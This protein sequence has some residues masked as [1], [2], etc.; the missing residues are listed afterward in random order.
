[1]CGYHHVRPDG[2]TSCRNAVFGASR[3]RSMPIRGCPPPTVLVP[4]APRDHVNWRTGSNLPGAAGVEFSLASESPP[5]VTKSRTPNVPR[6]RPAA[7]TTSPC[8]PDPSFAPRVTRAGSRFMVV[9]KRMENWPREIHEKFTARTGSPRPRGRGPAPRLS[10]LPARQRRRSRLFPNPTDIFPGA[11]PHSCA[12]DADAIRVLTRLRSDPRPSP[13]FHGD[14]HA[15]T[16]IRSGPGAPLVTNIPA[17]AVKPETR[18]S[19]RP[20]ASSRANPR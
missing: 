14:A 13:P 5:P 2:S 9:D 10:R 20:T 3:K 18:A 16:V 4:P 6:R 12:E 19:R 11:G 1:V 8:P 15:S 7:V 17:S